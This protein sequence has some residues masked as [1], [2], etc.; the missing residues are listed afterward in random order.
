MCFPFIKPLSDPEGFIRPLIMEF[1]TVGNRVQTHESFPK[2]FFCQ[3]KQQRSRGYEA[4]RIDLCW[5]RASSRGL[6]TIYDDELTQGIFITSGD[7]LLEPG[8]ELEMSVVLQA[9]GSQGR[10]VEDQWD[11]AIRVA[12][13]KQPGDPN[14]SRRYGQLQGLDNPYATRDPSST[15]T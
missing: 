12:E 4:N 6:G 2:A 13:R 14:Q 10:M 15:V 3:I 11:G 1:Q 9:A 5:A 7:A 8:E